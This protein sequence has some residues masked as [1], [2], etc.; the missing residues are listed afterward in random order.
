M[1]QRGFTLLEMLVATTI[2]AIAVVG[3]MSAISGSTRNAV[4][5]REYGRAVQLGR[6]RMNELLADPRLPRNTVLTGAY[7]PAFSG[8]M[9]AG[10]RAQLS[11]FEAPL[12]STPGQMALDRVELEIW[13][14]SGS[15]R[16]T[17]TLDGYR[18]HLLKAEE[19]VPGALQ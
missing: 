16:R 7:D 4:R 8:G 14:M 2:M 1:R 6:L 18:P 12:Q 5:L 13:W 10:W 15:Q 11:T 19:L 9:Q 3:L 17:F